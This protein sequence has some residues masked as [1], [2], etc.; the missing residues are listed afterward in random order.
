MHEILADVYKKGEPRWP[1]FPNRP[2]RYSVRICRK[3]HRIRWQTYILYPPHT[4][5]GISAKI[6]DRVL[7]EVLSATESMLEQAQEELPFDS[8]R[9]KQLTKVLKNR[10]LS[11]L[12]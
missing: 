4:H 11:L 5:G 8:H 1:F 6:A 3:L 2:R 12:P 9:L 10:R 7:R